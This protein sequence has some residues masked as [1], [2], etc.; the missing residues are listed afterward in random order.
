MILNELARASPETGPVAQ[1]ND[2]R[3]TGGQDETH[4]ANATAQDLARAGAETGS[5]AQGGTKSGEGQDK[6]KT[7]AALGEVI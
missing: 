1:G 5:T 2:T 6:T 4:H 7:S 3:S